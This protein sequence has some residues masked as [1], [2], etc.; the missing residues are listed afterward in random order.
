[1]QFLMLTITRR[2]ALVLLALSAA[3]GA[4]VA[5]IG[6]LLSSI[7]ALATAAGFSI[8][9]LGVIVVGLSNRLAWR[10]RC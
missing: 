9:V 10:T 4:A 1:M 7:V 3:T 6:L 5:T 2:Q 8:F